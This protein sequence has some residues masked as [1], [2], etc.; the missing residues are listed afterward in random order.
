MRKETKLAR[1]KKRQKALKKM[2]MYSEFSIKHQQARK[3]YKQA[4]RLPYPST[5]SNF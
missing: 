4:T 2:Q 3:L 1:K 5:T